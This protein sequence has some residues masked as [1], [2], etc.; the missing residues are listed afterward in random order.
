MKTNA[1]IEYN[2]SVSR[3]LDAD[4]AAAA[5]AAR[6]ELPCSECGTDFGMSGGWTRKAVI[7]V[8]L[9]WIP[10]RLYSCSWDDHELYYSCI[11]CNPEK[12]IPADFTS[13]TPEQVAAWL[14]R[15]CECPD[16][17]REGKGVNE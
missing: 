4:T 8:G 16:C 10:Y 12:N 7:S 15:R 5:R 2:A 6:A 1:S 17:V 11:Q 13:L 3:D 9:D 14:G